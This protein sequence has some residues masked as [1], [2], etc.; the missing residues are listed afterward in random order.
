MSFVCGFTDP[1]S[2]EEF[3]GVGDTVQEAWESMLSENDFLESEIDL[4]YVGFFQKIDVTRET[5]TV[6][7][8]LENPS[9]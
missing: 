6:W 8:T 7:E 9:F 4:E 5:K 1:T 3:W 2:F